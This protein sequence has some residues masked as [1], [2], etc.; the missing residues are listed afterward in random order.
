[1]RITITVR[2]NKRKIEK[3]NKYEVDSL[4]GVIQF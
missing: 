2:E 3:T 4:K 1:M